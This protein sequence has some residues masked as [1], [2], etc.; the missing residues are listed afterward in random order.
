MSDIAQEVYG[1]RIVSIDAV[2]G[3]EEVC[4]HFADGRYVRF[5]HVQDCCES[6]QLEELDGDPKDYEG[7]ALIRVEERTGTCAEVCGSKYADTRDYVP[8]SE[9]WT[10][11]EVFTTRGSFQMRWCG[12]SNGYYSERVAV[13]VCRG[14]S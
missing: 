11:Y 3:A 10:F 6:V 4:I 1:L 5:Y 7:A 9:T 14:A 13:E 12:I 8:E 2:V